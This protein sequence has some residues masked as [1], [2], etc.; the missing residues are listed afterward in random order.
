MP[1]RDYYALSLEVMRTERHIAPALR[2]HLI[3]K[4]DG[5]L[6]YLDHEIGQLMDHL[7]RVGLYENT[8][9]V[10]TADHGEAFGEHDL[11]QHGVSVY[12]D[13]LHVP[14]LIKWPK[15]RG[16][17]RVDEVVSGVDIMPTILEVAGGKIPKG[18]SGQSLS[19]G[20]AAAT[21]VLLSETHP[22]PDVMRLHPRFNRIERAIRSGR[23]KFIQSTAG[24]RELYDME[25][26]PFEK[27][28]LYAVAKNKAA[29]L[30]QI[31]TKWIARL[32]PQS[33]IPAQLDKEAL[34]RLK[35]LGYVQ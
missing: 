3:D 19:R 25:A 27:R 9:I 13:Q 20:G 10:I 29:E 30:E 35:A 6:S 14:L 28:N 4:Y 32:K 17:R 21:R 8:L 12:R 7:K 31:L 22:C 15:A 24:K 16:T 5:A 34:E 23:W 26:D 11:M 18:I 1:L 33:R 2:K